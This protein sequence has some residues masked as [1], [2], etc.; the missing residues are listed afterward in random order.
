MLKAGSPAINGVV[1]SDVP[2]DD[3]RGYPRLVP[4]DLGAVERQP[5]DS[6]L[7]PRLYLPLLR[8]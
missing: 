5:G 6:D 3:Q 7:A 2:N 1:G 8:R 4:Y